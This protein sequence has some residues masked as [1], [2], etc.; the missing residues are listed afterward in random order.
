MS[1]NYVP[2]ASRVY[3]TGKITATDA[4]T[5]TFAINGLK[6][7]YSSLTSKGALTYKVGQIVTV[8]G[9]QPASKSVLVATRV[10]TIR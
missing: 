9:T 6:V 10:S 5:G 4:S 7:D 1:D 2:G 3:V 8:S